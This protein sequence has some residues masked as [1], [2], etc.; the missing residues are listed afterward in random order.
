VG[1]RERVLTG[2]WVVEDSKGLEEGRDRGVDT[3]V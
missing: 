3:A 2:I 1:F